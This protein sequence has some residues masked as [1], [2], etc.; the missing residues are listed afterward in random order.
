MPPKPRFF[1]TPSDWRAW[2]EKHHASETELWVG[3]YKR[4]SGRP[5]ITWPESVDG[6][7][8]FGWIDGVRKSVNATSY[9]IRF[10]P[11][12]PG[13][14]W[15]EINIK[16]ATELLRE[17][18]M[19]PAALAAFAK[20][21]KSDSPAYSPEQRKTAKLPP[22]YEKQFRGQASAWEFFQSLAPG[23][24]RLS[25]LWV[26]SAKKE[27]TKLKRLQML[28]DYSL[29]RQLHPVLARPSKRN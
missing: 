11:R 25:S 24:Q 5:S 6:A 7:L 26:I 23:Y 29:R 14:V 20:R 18:L 2:L 8:C 21:G 4:D 22:H 16:R 3:F 19:H 15:S 17:G 10:T 9:M 28:I 27:E 13:S 1:A 12:K